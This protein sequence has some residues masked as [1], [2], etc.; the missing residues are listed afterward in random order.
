ML[1]TVALTQVISMY[2]AKK[3]KD[4]MKEAENLKP[5]CNNIKSL[6]VVHNGKTFS[7]AIQHINVLMG[8]TLPNA[9]AESA[10]YADGTVL[11]TITI[12]DSLV[13][14]DI[15]DAVLSH[16]IGHIVQGHTTR[17]TMF[18]NAIDL[19]K[20]EMEAD[21]YAVSQG[22][23]SKM[24]KFRTNHLKNTGLL[25][26]YNQPCLIALLAMKLFK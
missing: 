9:M 23:I 22:H 11:H 16:E 15:Y 19:V 6:D 8:S 3:I 13:G 21:A 4:N 24:I 17:T 7:I 1:T 10:R 26:D 20:K 2:Q 14:T 25:L 18:D 12:Q 5:V